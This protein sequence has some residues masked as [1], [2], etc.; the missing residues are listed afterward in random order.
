MD[1]LPKFRVVGVAPYPDTLPKRPNGD[2]AVE[3][4]LE[5]EGAAVG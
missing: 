2:E 4:A 1:E 3:L 5:V